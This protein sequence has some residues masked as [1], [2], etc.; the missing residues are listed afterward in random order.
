MAE[1]NDI[2]LAE[3]GKEVTQRA[4]DAFYVAVGLA[5]LTFQR[6][7]VQRVELEK[8]MRESGAGPNLDEVRSGVSRRVR[9]L[10]GM[11]EEALRYVD[12]TLEPIEGRLPSGARDVAK[13]VRDT[14]RE[15]R[16]QIRDRVAP[17]S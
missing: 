9:D 11:V 6:A 8:K 15:V 12:T 16:I 7:Q 1:R 5:V 14:A 4:K 2:D 17:P 10:D 13:Q 3:L